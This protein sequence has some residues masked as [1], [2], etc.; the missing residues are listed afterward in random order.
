M[1][2]GL[3]CLK[4]SL[5]KSCFRRPPHFFFRTTPVLRVTH[6]DVVG[7]VDDVDA[8]QSGDLAQRREVTATAVVVDQ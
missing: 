7:G 3:S 2:V 5:S 1:Y 8:V 4:K 6:V